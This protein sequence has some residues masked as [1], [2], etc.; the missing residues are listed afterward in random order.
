HADQ[1]ASNP[2]T[3]PPCS[4]VLGSLS[5]V[6]ETVPSSYDPA[7]RQADSA[8]EPP[9]VAPAVT[10]TATSQ[11]QYIA[12]LRET[13]ERYRREI[14]RLNRIIAPIR[15]VATPLR[16]A[17]RHWRRGSERQANGA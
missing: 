7:G 15:T 3:E 13:N 17:L 9:S 5:P 2:S 4:S 8:P 14:E 16:F 6:S 10:I 1:P 12:E 11:E